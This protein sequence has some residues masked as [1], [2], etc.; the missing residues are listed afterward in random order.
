MKEILL[1][2]GLPAAGKST[3]VKE[4][5]A[6]GYFR[7]N[8]DET[9]GSTDAQVLEVEK[10]FK[11]GITKVVLD[12][13]YHTVESRDS[14]IKYARKNKVTI[15]C[16][17]MGTTMEE[18][19]FNVTSRMVKKHG[20]LLDLKECQATKDPGMFPPAALYAAKK[21]LI[22]PTISEGFNYVKV[23]PFIRMADK[24]YNK[25]G[26]LLDFDGTLRTTKSGAKYP[27]SPD[28]I[29]I[30]PGR[31]EKLL[32]M[33]KQ[34]Y[35]L[36]GVSNQSG[37]AKGDL[38]VEMAEACFKKTMDLLGIKFP[39]KF[40]GHSVPPIICYCR[41]P[42][43]GMGVEFIEEY[44]LNPS[45]CIMVGDMTSDATFAKRCGFQ[46]VDADVFFKS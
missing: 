1:I 20:K 42:A 32:E 16:L 22:R 21:N 8:R 4:F 41:K 30:L 25:K 5:V 18:A 7:I 9:K 33:Q 35:I 37:V 2:A 28:D 39:V 23:A 40:C 34:G 10:A 44:K 43:P 19:Q 12:N 15:G 46:F 29:L 3:L 14:I 24:T 36:L 27:T 11:N 26:L 6:K 45:E 13:T 31:R 17:F 38:T